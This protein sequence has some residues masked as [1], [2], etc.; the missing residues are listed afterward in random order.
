MDFAR[1]AGIAETVVPIMV[2]LGFTLQKWKTGIHDAWKEEA[3]TQRERADRLDADVRRLVTEVQ[4]LR[5]ENAELR[6]QIRELL[7]R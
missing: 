2:F 1:L 5:F 7:D 6:A 4:S 3:A